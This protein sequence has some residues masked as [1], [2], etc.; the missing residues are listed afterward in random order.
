MYFFI[1][2]CVSKT[3]QHNK[4]RQAKTPISFKIPCLWAQKDV[5]DART[6][7][8]DCTGL[9]LQLMH[10]DDTW[11]FGMKSEHLFNSNVQ[12]TNKKANW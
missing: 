7:E 9:L 8:M 11:M 1:N 10:L 6:L 12:N 4:Q 5:F 3:T 2:T